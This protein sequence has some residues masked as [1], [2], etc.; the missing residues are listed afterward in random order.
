MR[1]PDLAGVPVMMKPSDSKVGNMLRQ[2]LFGVLLFCLAVL[3]WIALFPGCLIRDI[4][5]FPCPGCGM[6]RALLAA[7]HCDMAEAFRM[8]PLFWLPPIMMLAAIILAWRASDILTIKKASRIGLVLI[9][10]FIAVYIVRM[11]LF[12]PDV[13]PMTYQQQSLFGMIGRLLGWR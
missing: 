4:T 9:I 10:V 1:H 6:T 2:P 8:H 5:G 3:S 13:E 7:I 11:I 12:F